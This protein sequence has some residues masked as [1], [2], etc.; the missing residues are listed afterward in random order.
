[1]AYHATLAR[2]F[3]L[4]AALAIIAGACGSSASPAPSQ[5]ASAAPSS[6]TATAQPTPDKPYAGQKITVLTIFDTQYDFY[7]TQIAQFTK[8]TGI[9]VDYQQLAEDGYIDAV[10]VKLVGKDDTFD[11]FFYN[12]RK[13]RTFLAQNPPEPL[14]AYIADSAKTSA[15]YD[16]A[17]V[18][19]SF[20]DICT[21]DGKVYCVSIL[22]SGFLLFYNKDHFAEAGI[23]EPP[24]TFEQVRDD[25]IKLKTAGHAG[26]CMRGAAGPNVYPFTNVWG[27][28]V[29]YTD[30]Q[31]GLWVDAN[32]KPQIDTPG[33][34]AAV[35]AYVEALQKG[36]PKGIESYGFDTCLAD[37]QQARVSMWFDDANWYSDFENSDKSTV[38]GKVG[39]T[40][41]P[42][43]VV[44]PVL[45][46]PLCGAGS[47]GYGGAH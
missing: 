1:M 25:A 36:G 2:S 31:K 14:D 42:C 9:E 40:Y 38:A 10:T 23:T 41:L 30:G 33:T 44:N 6:G 32:W 5:P 24:T 15:D 34:I 26:F 11:V 16:Y 21:V 8:D 29:P 37:F 3:G 13:A 46:A 35:K 28:Y 22:G 20:Q 17:S 19:P 45:A 47:A 4:L 12:N 18:S 39:Y 43:Q 27:Q 7:A